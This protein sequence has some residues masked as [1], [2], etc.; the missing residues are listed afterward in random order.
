MIKTNISNLKNTKD[1]LKRKKFLKSELKFI[2]MK[3]FIQ[4]RNIQSFLR[5]SILIKFHLITKKKQ[6]ISSQYNVCLLTG[7]AKPTSKLTGFSRQYTKQYIDLGLL[8][9]IK[10][11]S[12]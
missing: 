1:F 12:Y 11:N 2:I 3:S 5:F 10:N 7:K 4:N 6:N 8:Q 9:N